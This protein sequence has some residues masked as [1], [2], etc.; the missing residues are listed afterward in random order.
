MHNFKQNFSFGEISEHKLI[1]KI[2]NELNLKSVQCKDHRFDIVIE[3]G[4][5]IEVK[6]DRNAQKYNS[7]FVEFERHHTCNNGAILST[8]SGISRSQAHF[9]CFYAYPDT[10]EIIIKT[11][12]LKKFIEEN[13]EQIQV[14]K[15]TQM[16]Q[17][18]GT[19]WKRT[20]FGYVIKI[21]D[22]KHMLNPFENLK[23]EQRKKSTKQ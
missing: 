12:D 19:F 22:I 5:T 17:L 15:L 2:K 3:N 13:K 8:K 10:N 14:T 1:L 7:F 18:N 16:Q 9:Y 6:T 21:D 23:I 20:M 4:N 11:S